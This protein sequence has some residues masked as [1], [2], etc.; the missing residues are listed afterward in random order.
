MPPT[1]TENHDM[2]T[3]LLLIKGLLLLSIVV[4][5]LSVGGYIFSVIHKSSPAGAPASNSAPPIPPPATESIDDLRAYGE[6][7]IPGTQTVHLPAGQVLVT[8]HA[9]TA[10]D[11]E[12]SLAIPDLKLAIDPP[13]GVAKPTATESVGGTTSIDND[14]WRPI[15]VAQIPQD[16]DYQ[17]VVEGQVTAFVSAHLAF[18]HPEA[19]QQPSPASPP[20]PASSAGSPPAANPYSYLSTLSRIGFV[21]ALVTLIGSVLAINRLGGGAGQFQ[22]AAELLASGQRVPGVLNSFSNT[23]RT[24]RSTG[25]TPSR[26]EFLDD[27]LFII[28]MELQLPDRAPVRGRSI[29]R[30]PRAEVPNLAVGRQLMCVVDTAKPARRFVVDWGD[31]PSGSP[32]TTAPEDVAAEAVPAATAAPPAAE[33]VAQRL[34]ELEN[35]RGAGAISDAEYKAKRE[36]IIADI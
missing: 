6:V 15:A 19:S 8:F 13:P 21:A 34:R 33:A 12:G 14:A 1:G 31:I 5:V 36:Q 30:V 20:G 17:V 4:L 23:G 26:P 18:G 22:S 11:I 27:P 28:D 3:P 35:L 7:P 29:Q 16:A 32:A 24:P 2:R 9:V 10:G 25:N